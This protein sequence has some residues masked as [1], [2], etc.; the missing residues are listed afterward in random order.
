MLMFD[1][2]DIEEIILGMARMVKENRYLREE[3]NSLRLEVA[4]HNAFVD[5][6]VCPNPEKEAKYNILSDIEQ[7]NNAAKMCRSMG[8]MTSEEY[9]EDWEE[10]LKQRM[11]ERRHY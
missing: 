5:T 9:I 3:N 10:E 11:E 7:Q 1:Q 8:W 2:Y 4:R 6:L